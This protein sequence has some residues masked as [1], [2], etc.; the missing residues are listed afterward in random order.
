MAYRDVCSQLRQ[1]GRELSTWIWLE[2]HLPNQ[3]SMQSHPR[4][5]RKLRGSES[6]WECELFIHSANLWY[7]ALDCVM[8][9]I[10]DLYKKLKFSLPFRIKQK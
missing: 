9:Y 5:R 2:L 6:S 7:K 10:R 8:L 3:K 1:R 4:A